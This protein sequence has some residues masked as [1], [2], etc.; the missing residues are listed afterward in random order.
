M[1]VT[2]KFVTHQPRLNI[3]INYVNEVDALKCLSALLDTKMS[4]YFGPDAY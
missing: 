4:F 3:G 2:N 1:I